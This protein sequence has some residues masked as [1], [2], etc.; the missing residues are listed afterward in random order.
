MRCGISANH[1]RV[2]TALWIRRGTSSTQERNAAVLSVLGVMMPATHTQIAQGKKVHVH[3]ERERESKCSNTPG[4]RHICS[5]Y[6]SFNFPAGLKFS[7]KKLENKSNG[8]HI[9]SPINEIS[10]H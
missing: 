7:N 9:R 10:F 8:K 3:V 2:V 4:E 6:Y 1:P 5:L